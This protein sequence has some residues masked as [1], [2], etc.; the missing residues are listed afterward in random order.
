MVVLDPLRFP[1]RF[2]VRWCRRL[3]LASFDPGKN[4]LQHHTNDTS[5]PGV[6]YAYISRIEAGSRYPS[7]MALRHLATK[8]GTTAA[9]TS[10]RLTL[11]RRANPPGAIV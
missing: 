4:A 8:L 1:L 6:S 3:S 11:K 9:S 7:E 5:L 2:N 10:R